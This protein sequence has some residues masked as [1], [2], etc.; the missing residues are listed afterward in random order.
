MLERTPNK[1]TGAQLLKRLV[2]DRKWT[3]RMLATKAEIPLATVQAYLQ[4][5]RRAST[6][7]MRKL[8][9][10]LCDDQTSAENLEAQLLYA[11][12]ENNERRTRFERLDAPEAYLQKLP[13]DYP[14]ITDGK[15]FFIDELLQR[16]FTLSVISEQSSPK[17]DLGFDLKRR[18]EAVWRGDADMLTGLCSLPRLKLLHY[19]VTPIRIS[20]GAVIDRAYKKHHDALLQALIGRRPYSLRVI[21]VRGEVG[22][23][24]VRQTAKVQDVVYVDD[25][26]PAALADRLRVEVKHT[27][28]TRGL[29]PVVCCDEITAMGVLKE[30]GPQGM[31][32]FPPSTAESIQECAERKE[33]PTH[34]AGF[35][36]SRRETELIGYL[37]AALNLLLETEVEVIAQSW[38]RAYET[39]LGMVS[40][41]LA[42]HIESS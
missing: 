4:G 11:F 30:F 20:I 6:N 32:V 1:P 40:S 21:A 26:K 2:A 36:V 19:Y 15:Q 5:G 38:A 27:D 9:R 35:A 39:M 29:I 31:L 8:A 37:D 41:C 24:H 42:G 14:P 22:D 18:V 13:F 16:L 28:P 10:V 33:L 34:L 17:L 25:L 7:N 23:V 3:A 12:A